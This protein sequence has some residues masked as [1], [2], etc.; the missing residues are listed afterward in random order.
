[1]N[2]PIREKA[3]DLGCGCV[4]CWYPGSPTPRTTFEKVARFIA[5]LAHVERVEVLPFHQLAAS[6]WA[7]LR[8]PY[9]LAD[10]PPAAPELVRRVENQFRAHALAVV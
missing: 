7:D 1:M 3:R 9:Q 2:T 8:L 10:V 5:T 4:T 6:K